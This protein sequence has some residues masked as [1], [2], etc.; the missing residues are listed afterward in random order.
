MTPRTP[1]RKSIGGDVA[2]VAAMMNIPLMPWQQHFELVAGEIIQDED[3]G[4]WVPAYPE[5]FATVMRQQGKTAGMFAAYNHRAV[6][7]EAYDGKPQAIA[8]SGQTG[9][10]ARQKFSKEHWPLI[11][12]SPWRQTVKRPRFA[13]ENA[14]LDYANGSHMT[15]WANSADSG[16]SLTIDMT[17]MD[18]IWADTDDRRE[19]AANPAMLTRLD[20]QK[21]IASTAGTDASVLFLRKQALGRAAV[22]AG[23]TTGMAYV[24]FSADPTAADYDPEDPRLWW[25]IMPALGYTLTERAVRAMMDELRAEDGDLSEFERAGLNVT[26][27][28]AGRSSS[29]VAPELWAAVVDHRLEAPPVGALVFGVEAKPDLAAASVVAVDDG[30]RCELVDHRHGVS[31]LVDYLD[32][33]CARS[34]GR[35]VVDVGG[36]LGYLADRLESRS[37]EVVRFGTQDVK[38][39]AASFMDV[40]ASA[41]FRVRPSSVMDAAVES[42]RKRKIGDGWSWDRFADGDI[43]PLAALTLGLHAQVTTEGSGGP[44]VYV[45]SR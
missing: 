29:P 42:A 10:L 32:A 7:W 33:A 13:A 18:E 5:A 25:S 30:L 31:W 26:Q 4:F 17:C 11:K 20:R 45:T 2:T 39:A 28:I 14:G 24:E 40:L 34:G 16:H 6:K 37:V 38:H 1:G 35:V 43:S 36:P 21:R 19:Q 9:S 12:R 3:T 27:S 8:Y 41:S 44:L 23:K 22:D 15:I